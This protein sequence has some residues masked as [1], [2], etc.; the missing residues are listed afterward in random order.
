MASCKDCRY[1]SQ[2]IDTLNQTFNDIGNE[3]AHFCVMWE[4]EIPIGVYNGVKSCEFFV[5]KEGNQ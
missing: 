1:Y 4:D 2:D 5:E 3:D